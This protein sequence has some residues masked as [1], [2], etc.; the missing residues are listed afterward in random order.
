M[1]RDITKLH[2][3]LQKKIPELIAACKKEGTNIKNG[4]CFGGVVSRD[5]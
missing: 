3:E 4:E 1:G 2:P 5:A